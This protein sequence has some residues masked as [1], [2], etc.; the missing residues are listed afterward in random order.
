MSDATERTSDYDL[1]E[2]IS[3]LTRLRSETVDQSKARAKE[4]RNLLKAV[5]KALE[6]AGYKAHLREDDGTASD[7]EANVDI[8]DV[9]WIHFVASDDGVS[10]AYKTKRSPNA[11]PQFQ[12]SPI[13]FDPVA[14]I[15]VGTKEDLF[16]RPVPGE[17]SR[18]PRKQSAVAA[19]AQTF[20]DLV[21]ANRPSPSA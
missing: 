7:D 9:E 18:G 11:V 15:F 6:S 16:Y 1:D 20:A 19:V 4:S 5:V 12:S 10:M 3:V 21:R 13:E 17:V 14:R 2:A 8:R